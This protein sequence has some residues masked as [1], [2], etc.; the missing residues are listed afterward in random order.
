MAEQCG[1]RG[2]RALLVVTSGLTGDAALAPGLLDA[3][4]RHD[5]R[6]VGP[7]CLGIV[8]TD[9]TVRLDPAFA[10]PAPSGSVGLVT[11]SGGVAIAVQ[12]ELGRL[13]LGVSMAVSTGDKYDVSGNDMLL[14]WHGDQRTRVAVLHLESFGNPR[15][16]S[17]F[18]R[19]LAERVPV[20]TVRSGSSAAGQRAA[21][22]RRC[23]PPRC[24]PFVPIRTWTRSSP[25]PWP[26][27]SP[28]PFPAPSPRRARAPRS[29]RS[30]SVRPST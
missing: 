14:W 28:I 24:P 25:S 18:A 12:T 9:P 1:R 13:G 15:K 3:L 27:R 26:P 2:V 19:R 29:S 20:L 5:M 23:S 16:F 17:R 7:N 6:M 22:S 30:G 10:E 4:R 8:N 11:K 21:A